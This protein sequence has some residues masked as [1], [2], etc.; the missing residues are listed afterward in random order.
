ME[1]EETLHKKQHQLNGGIHFQD[2]SLYNLA[3]NAKIL[4]DW[5]NN[6]AHFTFVNLDYTL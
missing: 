6:T 3:S 5:F 1:W 4:Q 2:L